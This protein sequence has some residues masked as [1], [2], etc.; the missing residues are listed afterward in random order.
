MNHQRTFFEDAARGAGVSRRLLF[1][2]VRAAEHVEATVSSREGSLPCV[3][4]AG[5]EAAL[6]A[7]T[8]RTVGRTRKEKEEVRY[9]REKGGRQHVPTKQGCRQRCPRCDVL[10]ERLERAHA[11]PLQA[12]S[13]HRVAVYRLRRPAR[14]G[15][16]TCV[17]EKSEVAIILL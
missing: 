15:V 3:R 13:R 9:R 6:F 2:A 8:S 1:T 17:V 7:Y 11:L 12:G 4:I 10:C 14:S 16:E 5:V